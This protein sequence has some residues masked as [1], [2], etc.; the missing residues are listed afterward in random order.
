MLF[1]LLD[2][3]NLNHIGGVMVSVLVSSVV[4]RGFEPCRAKPKTIKL[5]CVA[6]PLSTR[7][8]NDWLIR[9]Q[10]NA[11][12]WSNMSTHGRLFQ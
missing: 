9:N 2:S 3:F 12:E 4:D 8:N 1:I 7:K 6:S 5:V 11:P 10:D